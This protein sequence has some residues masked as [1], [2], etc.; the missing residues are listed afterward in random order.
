MTVRSGT[1][2]MVRGIGVPFGSGMDVMGPVDVNTLQFREMGKSELPP[3]RGCVALV[4][5]VH[6]NGM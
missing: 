5:G 1:I 3:A 2:T 6:E 4:S